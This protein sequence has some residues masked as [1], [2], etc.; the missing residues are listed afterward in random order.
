MPRRGGGRNSSPPLPCC[1]TLSAQGAG[2]RGAAVLPIRLDCA[3]QAEVA[4]KKAHSMCLSVLH[5]RSG[6]IRPF[7]N[8]K[9]IPGIQR[10]NNPT[11]IIR[12]E[13]IPH[14]P[15]PPCPP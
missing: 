8:L 6:P 14:R 12:A 11:G 5:P 15:P 1:H 2:S 9:V 10:E 3:E 13:G 4:G 7:E